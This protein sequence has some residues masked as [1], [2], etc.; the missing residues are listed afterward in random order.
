MRQRVAALPES[1][2]E[3]LAAAAVLSRAISRS[4]LEAMCRLEPAALIAGLDAACRARLLE[5]ASPATYRFVHDV[6]REALEGD[7]GPA[8]R[9]ALHLRAGEALERAPGPS[10][11]E[12]LAYHFAR[13][14]DAERAVAYLERAG[15]RARAQH[16][17]E[18]TAGYYRE[19]VARLAGM[20][21]PGT[22]ATAC[23]KL[24]AVFTILTHYDEALEV[25]ERAAS[26]HA[27][28]GALEERGQVTAQIGYIHGQKGAPAEGLARLEP[29]I[30]LLEARGPSPALVQMYTTRSRMCAMLYLHTEELA[31]AARAMALARAMGDDQLLAGV[32][33]REG[34]ALIAA[35]RVAESL[36][37]LA[38]ARRLAE[39]LGDLSSLHL[40]HSYAS[41]GHYALG[42]LAASVRCAELALDAAR[43]LGDPEAIAYALCHG[44]RSAFLMGDWGPARTDL[45]EAMALFSR[46]RATPAFLNAAAYLGE[47]YLAAGEWDRAMRCAQE[48]IVATEGGMVT[49]PRYRHAQG[50]LAELDLYCGRPGSARDRLLPLAADE[51]TFA[52]WIRTQLAWAYLE[53]GEL[54]RATE[55]VARALAQ[56]RSERHLV[57]LVEA[58]RVQGMVLAGRWQGDQAAMALEEGLALAPSLPFP[59]GEARLLH[60]YG[61]LHLQRGEPAAARERLEAA[62]AIFRRLGARKDTERAEQLLAALH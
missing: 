9:A 29:L 47:S 15:D 14:D 53:L 13:A 60:I 32:L 42:E 39:L 35:G 43:R 44:G 56:A 41:I 10:P 23:E 33:V 25:L 16:A 24:G 48:V 49:H 7:L 5:E 55:L 28:A 26:I 6:I 37:S 1:A 2:Q 30:A 8:R 57:R 36:R 27:M 50:L 4:L 38:E 40:A 46:N 61:R 31:A 19:L 11:V 18:A 17:H 20:E 12:A 51:N 21:R 59:Y 52:T 45:E 34:Y 22:L 58:L 3:V 62:L 54:D